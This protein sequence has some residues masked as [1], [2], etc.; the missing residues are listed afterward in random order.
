MKK[1]CNYMTS[2]SLQNSLIT[3]CIARHILALK[4][5]LHTGEFIK[6]KLCHQLSFTH[7]VQ[8]THCLS[9][10]TSY[11]FYLAMHLRRRSIF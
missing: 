4:N 5:A 6:F 10:Y 8:Y 1:V 11:Y 7:I 9:L 2:Y 3:D